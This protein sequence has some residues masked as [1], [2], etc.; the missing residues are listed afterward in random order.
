MYSRKLD[1]MYHPPSNLDRY[2]NEE[3]MKNPL[4][5]FRLA[6]VYERRHHM[7]L[8]YR[9]AEVKMKLSR[10]RL[11]SE[12]DIRYLPESHYVDNLRRCVRKI[13]VPKMLTKTEKQILSYAPKRLKQKL[14]DLVK[15]YMKDVHEEFDRL[16]KIYSMKSILVNP[17]LPGEDPAEFD[18][19]KADFRFSLPGK[20]A[21]YSKFVQNRKKIK[22]RLLILHLPVR[23]V[24][25]SSELEFPELLIIF[26][27]LQLKM[28]QAA[29]VQMGL[30]Q[31]ECI[32]HKTL[33]KYCRTSLDNNNTYLRWTWY[34]KFI[35]SIRRM[36]KKKVIPAKLWPATFLCIEGLIN[37]QLNNLKQR[38]LMELLKVC[39]SERK[40]PMLRLNLICYDEDNSIDISPSIEE[41][42]EVYETIAK[43]IAD[44]GTRME[45]IQPQI[46]A[47]TVS[48]AAEYLRINLNTNYLNE[49]IEKLKAVIVKTYKPIN[50][51]LLQY[52]RKYY[53]L[54]SQTV[55]DDLEEFL[56][57]PRAFEEYFAKIDSYFEYINLLRS[58]PRQDFFVLAIINNEPAIKRLRQI[59]D[60]LIAR[61]TTE[62]TKQHIKTE[63][64][65]CNDFQYIK[66]RALEIPKTT[67]EL[68]AAA[69][70]MIFV[71]KEKLF[72]LRNRIQYCLK[73]GTNLVE[74][75][76]M[77]SYHF[78]LTIT[79]ISW[80]Y[81]IN[82]ICDYNA[83]QQE[84][85]KCL[86]EEH[87]QEVVKKLNED[88]EELIP[89]ITII[90]DMS[91]PKKFKEYYIMLQ[92]FIDQLKIFDDYVAWI[93]K[94]EKLFKI[95]QT[96][97]PTL[98]VLKTFVYPFATLM[99]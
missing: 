89:K 28:T 84:N 16:M 40:I 48:Q 45:P 52:Q 6:D 37:R 10:Q 1:R 58:E 82:E 8:K 20:T 73:V 70:Y 95:P 91:D 61:I 44:V 7:F 69:E 54:Y 66:D 94:E 12:A 33:L 19:P 56:S 98:E 29:S 87:L 90:N 83:S 78:D 35:C 96:L 51:Y 85:Y 67:E 30:G 50:Q 99:K 86:F 39:S 11:T 79:T 25:N 72:E 63:L 2:D 75:C 76:E 31:R 46:D 57:E 60:G 27:P 13:V 47:S 80:L 93:N 64:D 15:S 34:P 49:F 92:N 71:K 41:I 18:L 3:Y 17:A 32:S 4:L 97:Y 36:H 26:D 38:T 81:D 68:L 65:I 5:K 23:C 59:A 77:S 22:Q 74:L 55:L 88:I 53:N 62:I 24:L 14:P 9:A 42:L 21:N 43:E